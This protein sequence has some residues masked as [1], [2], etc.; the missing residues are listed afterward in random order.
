[1]K[2]YTGQEWELFRN[3][4]GRIQFNSICRSCECCCK[5]TFRA[6]IVSCRRHE[7]RKRHQEQSEM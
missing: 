6:E 2:K 4:A 5:Q 1:M 3:Q 7:C